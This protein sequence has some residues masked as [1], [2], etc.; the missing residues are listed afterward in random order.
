MNCFLDL[1]AL[2]QLRFLELHSNPLL[3]HV[4]VAERI[5]A[6]H[7]YPAVIGNAESFDAFHRGGLPR[8]VWSYQ[9]KDLT[10]VNVERNIFDGDKPSVSFAEIGDLND[11]AGSRHGREKLRKKILHGVTENSEL[12]GVYSF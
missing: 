1:Y 2:L 11:W 12:H 6:K 5:E 7:R 10:I 4:N 8:P 3:K 9:P